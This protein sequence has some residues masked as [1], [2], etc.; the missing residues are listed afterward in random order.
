MKDSI[1]LFVAA[2]LPKSL[3]EKLQDQLIH[4]QHPHLRMLPESNLHL[5]FYFI[6]NVPIQDLPT[7]KH[8]IESI[9][10]KY[11][12]FTLT[13]MQTEAGPN[14][15]KPRLIWARFLPDDQFT[16]LSIELTQQLSDKKQ[17]TKP[18]IPHITLARYRKDKPVPKGLPSIT[19]DEMLQLPVKTISLWQSELASPHPVYTVLQTYPLG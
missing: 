9:A 14:P 5:T 16:Q 2:T 1:R 19:S 12:P 4:F 15:K 8:A 10:Q 6:G 13:F 17:P 18:P 11:T 3:I 7:I